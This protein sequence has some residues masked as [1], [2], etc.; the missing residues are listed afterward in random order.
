[1]F[2][3]SL[4]NQNIVGTFTQTMNT[5]ATITGMFQ[6]TQLDQV[7]NDALFNE[8]SNNGFNPLDAGLNYIAIDEDITSANHDYY[9]N[10]VKNING[11]IDNT[12]YHE[13]YANSYR[14][15]YAICSIAFLMVS[16]F[17]RFR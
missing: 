8:L 17:N 2:K 9:I 3:E 15:A 16:L 7:N 6:N 12:V 1:M 13:T 5:D 11:V 14:R 10:S 4:F